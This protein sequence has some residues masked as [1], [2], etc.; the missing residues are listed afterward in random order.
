MNVQLPLQLDK[1]A[2]LHWVQ[3]QEGRFELANGRAIMMAGASRT[4]GL[5]VSNLIAILRNQLDPRE[6]SVIADFGVDAGPDTLR[7][8]DIVVDPGNGSGSDFTARAPALVIE[9]LSP[10]TERIDLGD[11]AAEY[12]RLGSLKAYLVFAQ[13]EAK[14]WVWS[15]EPTKLSPAPAVI[16]G[17]DKIVYIKELQLTLPMGAV[18]AGTDVDRR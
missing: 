7:Y 3:G 4:H 5:V 15:G 17:L 1:A 16:G 9:V 14:A 8:P 2:F 10:S 13:D 11:K 12:L 18:Y 6:W